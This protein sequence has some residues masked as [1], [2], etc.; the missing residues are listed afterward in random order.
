MQYAGPQKVLRTIVAEIIEN[1]FPSRS[2]H[3]TLT[4]EPIR[5]QTLLL[6][7]YFQLVYPIPQ[8]LVLI[9]R[10]FA[11]ESGEGFGGGGVAHF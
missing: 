1:A 2:T 10:T 6:A 5:G 11:F 8:L 4:R 9:P 3:D 7:I